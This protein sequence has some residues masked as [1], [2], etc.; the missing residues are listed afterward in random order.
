MNGNYFNYE[1]YNLGKLHRILHKFKTLMAL[2]DY[3]HIHVTHR[4]K[5]FLR[6]VDGF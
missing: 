5:V 6:K 1:K 3:K 2:D 4:V